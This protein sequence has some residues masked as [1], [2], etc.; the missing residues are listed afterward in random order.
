MIHPVIPLLQQLPTFS[1]E[2]ACVGRASLFDLDVARETGDQ[3]EA[4]HHRARAL[5]RVCPALEECSDAVAAEPARSRSG[6]W[7]AEL[8]GLRRGAAW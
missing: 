5:C 3:R 1:G 4:R 7:A 2:P 6:V 8:F